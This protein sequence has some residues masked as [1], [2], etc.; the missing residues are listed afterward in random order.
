MDA[1]CSSPDLDAALEKLSLQDLQGILT[2]EQQSI[3]GNTH[4]LKARIKRLVEARRGAPATQ[5]PTPPASIEQVTFSG[6]INQ[7][8]GITTAQTRGQSTANFENSPNSPGN[9]DISNIS[10]HSVAS[11]P[12]MNETFIAV[13]SPTS[14]LSTTSTFTSMQPIVTTQT[15]TLIY[16]SAPNYTATNPGTSQNLQNFPH[17]QN[18]PI[19]SNSTQWNG[20]IPN[21]FQQSFLPN[22]MNAMQNVPQQNTLAS[23]E[24]A[25]Q[26]QFNMF[27]LFSNFMMYMQ[28]INAH[29]AT[30]N[31]QISTAQCLPIN[32]NQPNS[33][34]TSLSTTN[35]HN[36]LTAP[37]A[38]Q[39]THS[40]E[41]NLENLLD[42][43]LDLTMF[44][45]QTPVKYSVDVKRISHISSTF[46]K[47]KVFFSGKQ[48][49]DPYRFIKYLEE[50]SKFM[51]LSES[52]LFCSLPI[53]LT[54]EALEWFRLEE[55]NLSDFKA[56]K[57]AFLEHYRIPYY[58]DRLM[59]DARQRT[60]A[61]SE[62]I[63]SFIT[64]IRIIFDKMNPK[65]SLSRQLDMTC[66]NLNPTYA[67][68]INRSQ[69]NSFEELLTAGKQV[70]IKLINVRKYKEPPPPDT[71]VLA[72][73]AWHP[74]KDQAQPVKKHPK[75]NEKKTNPKLEIASAK[76]IS[77]VSKNA[78]NKKN[79]QSSLRKEDKNKYSASPESTITAK[80]TP[81]S[82]SI[83]ENYP[84]LPRPGECFKC[85]ESGHLFKSCSN[86]PIF[87]IFC[88]SCGRA[89]VIATKCPTCKKAEGNI[90]RDQP[91]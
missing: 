87:R 56:F 49:S 78:G 38:N 17:L 61:L 12:S 48:G 18:N 77:P 84:E 8:S 4:V 1:L 7:I 10:I 33:N 50:S 63:T 22:T 24:S 27:T 5:F 76:E 80:Q 37:S 51:G 71:A 6:Q 11:S 66:Q 2:R 55:T 60:Q 88:Y 36:P 59:E 69:I 29:N 57:T 62:P 15:G 41:V 43:N 42:N 58:Q 21:Y 26:N 28:S 75:S 39:G 91:N 79:L 25:L 20:S 40:N 46:E 82:R 52:E 67:L 30:H 85:R 19:L 73:A 32:S 74:P 89:N 34:M 53:V 65:L 35:Q 9:P 81:A 47:R 31:P 90:K 83:K 14:V 86:T 68:Q 3:Q 54:N 70:E 44:E 45:D 13:T 16:T 72:N 64:C 23:N